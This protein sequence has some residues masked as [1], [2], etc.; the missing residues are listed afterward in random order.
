MGLPRETQQGPGSIAQEPSRPGPDPRAARAWS[1]WPQNPPCPSPPSCHTNMPQLAQASLGRF[2]TEQRAA[3]KFT[4]NSSWLQGT[5]LTLPTS[6][7][8]LT[9]NGLGAEPTGE[10]RNG[11]SLLAPPKSARLPPHR[12]GP[13]SDYSGGSTRGPCSL[14]HMQTHPSCS[15]WHLSATFLPRLMAGEKGAPFIKPDTHLCITFYSCSAV[16]LPG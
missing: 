4:V 5:A 1:L 16:T 11:G 12:R 7:G 8:L 14:T 3:E 2:L 10:K 13:G 15:A 6:P 9:A